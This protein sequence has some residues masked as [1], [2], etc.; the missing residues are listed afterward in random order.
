MSYFV[1]LFYSYQAQL[2]G[3]RGGEEGR[4]V[5]LTDKITKI[6]SNYILD[7]SFPC[8]EHSLLHV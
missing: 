1:P 5:S 7:A 3:R 6:F 4:D 2:T 8:T